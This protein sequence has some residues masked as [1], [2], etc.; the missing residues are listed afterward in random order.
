MS[1]DVETTV[2]GTAEAP[3]K[4]ED[5]TVSAPAPPGSAPTATEAQEASPA[6]PVQPTPTETPVVATGTLIPGETTVTADAPS[7]V[8]TLRAEVAAQ[9]EAIAAQRAAAFE[10]LLDRAGVLPAYREMVP[11]KNPYTDKGRKA[12]QAWLDEHPEIVRHVEAPA[13]PDMV[14][15]AAKLRAMPGGWLLS[16][17]MLGGKR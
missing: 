2:V 10:T 16:D 4:P 3:S 17:E 1:E 14:E 12:L 8:E 11:V 9:R 15:A 6:P 5:A 13:R 7:E